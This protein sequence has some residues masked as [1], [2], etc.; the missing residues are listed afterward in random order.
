[1]AEDARQAEDGDREG[2]CAPVAPPRSR[3]A[4]PRQS[5]AGHSGFVTAEMEATLRA[6]A[7]EA[8]ERLRDRITYYRSLPLDKVQ[9]GEFPT[10]ENIFKGYRQVFGAVPRDRKVA[11]GREVLDGGPEALSEADRAVLREGA[12]AAVDDLDRKSVV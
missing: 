2:V 10:C 9:Q 3:G 6:A 5:P 4:I 11:A 8:A 7:L 12:E 1:M